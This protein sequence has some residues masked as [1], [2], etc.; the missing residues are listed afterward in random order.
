VAALQ[1]K[2]GIVV[3]GT[4]GIGRAAA[5]AVSREGAAVALSGREQKAA[6]ATA[7][8]IATSTEG[9]VSG[10][11]WDIADPAAAR[12]A[13][14]TCLERLGG[15][16]FAIVCAGINPYWKRATEVTP[17]IW[18]HLMATN[19]R[20]AFFAVQAAAEPMLGAYGGGAIV[21]TS[22]M[23]ATAGVPR[24]LPYVASKGGLEAMVRSLAVE[25]AGEGVRINAISPGFIETDLTA[26]VRDHPEIRE[27]ILAGIPLGRF[28][29][30]EEV[31]G[32]AAVLV[33]DVAS[34]VTG[35][36]VQV[37]GG[38]TAS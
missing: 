23:T 6:D 4:R 3:G 37:D 2:R 9:D 10:M 8:E 21:V 16:D 35:Q 12:P 19:L 25:W 11:G 13:V 31:A 32:L 17:E 28:G 29:T 15:L 22:S 20:G 34:Y 18:D 38:G 24:G 7:R 14:G 1:G 5:L 26:G 36:V 33:S 30:V 27:S